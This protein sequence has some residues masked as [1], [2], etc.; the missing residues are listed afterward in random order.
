MTPAVLESPGARTG[1]VVVGRNEGRRLVRC[2]DAL[3]RLGLPTVY[4]DSGSTD[5]SVAEARARGLEVVELDRSTPF[6]AARARNEGWRRLAELD[7]ALELVQFV[8]GDCVLDDGWI[9]AG[10]AALRGAPRVAAVCGRR[11][12]IAPEASLYNRLC[13]LE[14]DTEP[15]FDVDCGGDALMRVAALREVGGF[16]PSLAA[17]EEP[18]LCMRL[19]ARGHQ[20]QRIG[21]EMTLH[22]AAIERFSQW[23][24]RAVRTGYTAAQFWH[25]RRTP[26]GRTRLRRVLSAILWA[27]AVPTAV[28][29]SAWIAVGRGFPVGPSVCVAVL[30]ALGSYAVPFTRARRGRLARGTRGADATWYALFCLVGKVPELQGVLRFAA[31]RASGRRA[32]LIEYKD[33]PSARE[34]PPSAGLGGQA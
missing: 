27:A 13:D 23:W 12:E 17:G 32:A 8:D 20:V 31:H 24:N 14:W 6:T 4:V 10:Q 16:D 25:V 29:A 11:R 3:T 28:A 1:I 18:E 30:V 22:D 26:L 15:G 7:P 34:S 33:V 9:P 21:V 19:R 5:G 2:L